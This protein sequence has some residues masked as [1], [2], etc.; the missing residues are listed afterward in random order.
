[1]PELNKIRSCYIYIEGPSSSYRFQLLYATSGRDAISI[2]QTTFEE[3]DAA[4]TSVIVTP[5]KGE[6]V[7]LF[8]HSGTDRQLSGGFVILVT[9]MFTRVIV[10]ASV[11]DTILP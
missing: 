7:R 1:M 6:D 4:G 10:K 11:C 2:D 3:D 5:K 8:Y 9:G